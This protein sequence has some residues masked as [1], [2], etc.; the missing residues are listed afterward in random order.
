MSA[1]IERFYAQASVSDLRTIFFEVFEDLCSSAELYDSRVTASR[2][3]AIDG[4]EAIIDFSASFSYISEEKTM[5]RLKVGAVKYHAKFA[6]SYCESQVREIID[7][8]K[9]KVSISDIP[10]KIGTHISSEE[11]DDKNYKNLTKYLMVATV[12][13]LFCILYLSSEEQKTYVDWRSERSKTNTSET[14]SQERIKTKSDFPNESD[15]DEGEQQKIFIGIKSLRS[16]QNS[17]IVDFYIKKDLQRPEFSVSTDFYA[18]DAKKNE[19]AKGHLS[20]RFE[21]RFIST[22][23]T[24]NMLMVSCGE[25]DSILI[26]R[27]LQCE[28]VVGNSCAK[29]VTPDVRSATTVVF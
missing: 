20:V 2:V 9:E 27:D 22:Q 21:N 24:S 26:D 6:A 15:E 29:N 25:I 19:R 1:A 3:Q 18:L 5:V 7:I 14:N 11:S 8:L 23:W 10:I 28:S 16:L 13:L 4:M 17:C 12:V